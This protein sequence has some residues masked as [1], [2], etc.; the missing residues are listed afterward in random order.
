MTPSLF[1]FVG[2]MMYIFCAAEYIVKKEIKLK[3]SLLRLYSVILSSTKSCVKTA[4]NDQPS[5]FLGTQLVSLMLI[6]SGSSNRCVVKSLLLIMKNRRNI[7]FLSE[8]MYTNI[9]FISQCE[10]W[11]KSISEVQLKTGQ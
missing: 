6:S 7:T 8:N 4:T 10:N 1:C 3:E 11:G 9:Y 2:N 5:C